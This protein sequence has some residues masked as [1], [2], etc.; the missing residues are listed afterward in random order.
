MSSDNAAVIPPQPTGAIIRRPFSL[1]AKPAGAA[2]NLNCSYCFFLSKQVLWDASAQQMSPEVLRVWLASYLDSQPDGAVVIGWQGGEPTLRGIDFFRQA[3]QLAR[4]LA[5]PGQQVSHS[6]QTNGTLLDDQWGELLAANQVLVGIS[7]DGPAELH[8]AHRVNKAGRGSHAQVVRGWRVL[9]RHGVQANILCTVNSANADH[10][11]PV[12]RHFRDE[13]G[14]RFVQFIPIVER[15][16]AGEELLAEAGWL[17]E[18]GEF[19]LYRQ[20]GEQVTSRTVRPQQ[21]GSFLVAVFDEW[22]SGDVGEVFVQHFDVA[23]AALFGQYSLC[24]HAPGC[25]TALAMEP[26]GDVYACDHYVEPGYRLGNVLNQSLPAMLA[27]PQQRQFGRTKAS[28]LPSQCRSCPV[29]WVCHGGCPKDRFV[30]TAAGEPGLNYLC[31]GYRQFFGHI[32]P[33]IGR[34]A[35]L[36]RAGRPAAEIMA[37][38]R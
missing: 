30:H 22:L 2:C 15:V 31:A 37:Q 20:R 9:Q 11:L 19:V 33:A 3:F 12:Y 8:D 17:D 1:L 6:I 27:A 38:P 28:G 5:R 34:M 25:G 24:V 14:A 23:L 21:W 7:L 16:S 4:E 26:G 13:L 35:E 18:R 29:R 32:S 36:V 10:P